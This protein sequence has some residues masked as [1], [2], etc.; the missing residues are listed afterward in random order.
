MEVSCVDSNVNRYEQDAELF[1]AMGHPVRLCILRGLLDTRGCNVS[2]IQECLELPQSTVSQ[3]L[4]KLKAAGLIEGHRSGT[5]I[6]Y[7]V[8]NPKVMAIISL[9]YIEEE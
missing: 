4:Q 8:V 9:L 3:H 7:T 6:T 5:E 1:K 2:H